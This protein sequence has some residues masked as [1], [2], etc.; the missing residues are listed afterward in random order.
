[1]L[2]FDAAAAAVA[3]LCPLLLMI[4][5]LPLLLCFYGTHAATPMLPICH[6]AML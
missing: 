3:T 5:L 4:L 1:M 6:A 2:R